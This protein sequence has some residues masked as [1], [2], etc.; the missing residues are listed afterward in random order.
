MKGVFLVWIVDDEGKIIFP[1]GAIANSMFNDT[2]KLFKSS[3][4]L[5]VPLIRTGIA[6][7][8]DKRHKFKNPAQFS[9]RNDPIWDQFVS[10]V[11]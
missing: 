3:N 5:E 2:F 1:C 10:P 4:S 8:T 6:W 11:G 7:D 9:D